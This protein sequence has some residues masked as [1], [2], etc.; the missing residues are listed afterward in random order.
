M[1]ISNAA[2]AQQISDLLSYWRDRDAEYAEWITGA[3]NGGDYSD[4][5]YPLTDYAGNTTY[6]KS[7]PQ[8]E[9]E[10]ETS[11]T[12]AAAYATAASTSA[13]NAATS[14]TNASSSAATAAVSEANAATSASAASTSASS[15]SSHASNAA[16]SASNASTSE[17]NAQ[18][19]HDNILALWG[20]ASSSDIDGGSITD[21]TV[22]ATFDGGSLV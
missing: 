6:V 3:V 20:L 11:A 4:G 19:Y 1:P 5:T 18:T 22:T 2:L 9:Y 15:A 10:V 12:S 13:T 21:P 7:P 8:L 16:T 17:T 14:A